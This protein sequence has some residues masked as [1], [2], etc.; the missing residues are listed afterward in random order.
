MHTHWNFLKN[1]VILHQ[2]V[3][4]HNT[5]IHL[6]NGYWSEPERV[7]HMRGTYVHVHVKFVVCLSFCRYVQLRTTVISYKISFLLI[8]SKLC[9]VVDNVASCNELDK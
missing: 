2:K 3:Q 9:H 7:S 8:V 6:P 5:L 4:A 1:A